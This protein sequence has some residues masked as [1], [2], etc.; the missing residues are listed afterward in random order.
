MNSISMMLYI[1]FVVD[2][3]FGVLVKKMQWPGVGGSNRGK[4]KI[5]SESF[6]WTI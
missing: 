6:D 4:G 2:P 1:A 5:S 3:R